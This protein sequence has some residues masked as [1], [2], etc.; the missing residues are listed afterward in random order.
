M[1]ILRATSAAEPHHRNRAGREPAVIQGDVIVLFLLIGVCIWI[2]HAAFRKTPELEAPHGFLQR[3]LDACPFTIR[4]INRTTF[5]IRELDRFDENPNIYVK[6]HT[7]ILADGRTVNL[8]IV[9][10]TGCGTSVS[11]KLSRT[12]QWNIRTFIDHH[13]NP[14]SSIPYLVILSHCHY[15]HILGLNPILRP[16]HMTHSTRTLIVSSGYDPSFIAPSNL[17]KHSLCADLGLRLPPYHT[18]VWAQHA[19]SLD[20]VHP[21]LGAHMQLPI[22]TLHTPGHTPDSLSWYDADE[23]ALYVGDAFYETP[24]QILFPSEG[25]LKEWWRSVDMLIAFVQERNEAGTSTVTLSAGHVTAGV[26]AL[27]CLLG[28]KEFMVRVLRNEVQFEEEP[29]KRGER[30]GSWRE[31]GGRFSLGAPLRLIEEGRKAILEREWRE[32]K[33]GVTSSAVR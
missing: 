31:E 2:W 5:L 14:S 8:L 10:D 13:L 20:V 3:Q 26:D 7:E 22:I 27:D 17:R 25:N 30:F 28:V 19:Q 33:I 1:S 18:S 23:R 11:S 24:A 16:T 6:K 29:M 15:D 32:W 9:N 21:K 4:Q 12:G